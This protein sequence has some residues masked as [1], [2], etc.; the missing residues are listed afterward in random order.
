[1]EADGL[2][3]GKK[4]SVT[5][6]VPGGIRLA[7]HGDWFPLEKVVTERG[8]KNTPLGAEGLADTPSSADTREC[9][10]RATTRGRESRI[11]GPPAQLGPVDSAKP[12]K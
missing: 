5:D 2:D 3:A 11:M 12:H 8:S 9:R 1:M 6:A 10:Y 4:C 7:E